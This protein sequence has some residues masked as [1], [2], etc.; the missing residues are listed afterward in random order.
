[1]DAHAEAITHLK[2]AAETAWAARWDMSWDMNHDDVVNLADLWLM[3]SWFFFAPGDAVLL[4]A[5]IYAT[6]VALFAG[7]DPSFLSGVTS[8]IFSAVVW[9]VGLG[10]F[11]RRA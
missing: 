5:M 10:F 2:A 1:M 6:P 7:L 3:T 11:A 9:L 8:G 4:L